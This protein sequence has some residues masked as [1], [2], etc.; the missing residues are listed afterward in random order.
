M[1]VAVTGVDGPSRTSDDNPDRPLDYRHDKKMT[2]YA[3]IAE[4]NGFQFMPVVFPHTGQI[5]NSIK[6]LIRYQIRHKLILFEGEARQSMIRSAVKW[7][8]KC[9]SI[10]IAKTG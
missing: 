10:V 2:K 3:K 6:R 4:E 1:D 7:W 5:H 8:S 9:V